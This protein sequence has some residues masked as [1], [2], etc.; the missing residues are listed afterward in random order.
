MKI[1]VAAFA[2][3]IATPAAAQPAAQP[4]HS[5]HGQQHQGQQGHG[6]HGQGESGERHDCPCCRPAADGSRPSCCERMHQQG[7]QQHH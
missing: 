4:D 6:Q 5:Q 1:I 2:L 3:A 7:G